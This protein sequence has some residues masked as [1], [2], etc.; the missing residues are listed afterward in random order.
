MRLFIAID[1]PEEFCQTLKDIQSALASEGHLVL[2]KSFHLTLKFLGD[3]SE[4]QAFR[5]Q[6]GLKRVRFRP[7]QLSTT[8]LGVFPNKSYIRVVWLGLD[9]PP[10]LID[11]L[12]EIDKALESYFPKEKKFIPHITLARVKSISNKAAFLEKLNISMPP[13]SWQVTSASLYRSIL[14]PTGPE[15]TELMK[16]DLG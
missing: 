11:L 1:L 12:K 2:T 9:S 8:H 13:L 4:T 3:V 15:Y 5:I 7:F 14:T 10:R 16:I 6:E